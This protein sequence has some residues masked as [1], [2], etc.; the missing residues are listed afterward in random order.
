MAREYKPNAA[1]NIAVF[2]VAALSYTLM[3]V[4]ML[5]SSNRYE[6]MLFENVRA[7][8]QD[9]DSMQRVFL[10]A[11]TIAVCSLCLWLILLLR[12]RERLWESRWFWLSLVPLAYALWRTATA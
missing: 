7:L 6:W 10:F 4:L 5:Q 3:L 12:H 1:L 8:P 2:A 9:T 11:K